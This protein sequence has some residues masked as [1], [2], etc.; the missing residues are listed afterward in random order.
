MLHTFIS[1]LAWQ[2]TAG[3][4]LIPTVAYSI[5]IFIKAGIFSLFETT[6]PI[7]LPVIQWNLHSHFTLARTKAQSAIF[8][9]PISDQIVFHCT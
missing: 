3:I 5:L 8:L 4:Y 9:R 2:T 1:Y 7:Y 6:N